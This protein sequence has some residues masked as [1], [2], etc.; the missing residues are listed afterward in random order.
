LRERLHHTVRSCCTSNPVDKDCNEDGI[1]D[2]V[3]EPENEYMPIGRNV[4]RN[5]GV[6][7]L[8]MN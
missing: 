2:A 4:D 7:F 5:T 1:E 8:L 6:H 3:S